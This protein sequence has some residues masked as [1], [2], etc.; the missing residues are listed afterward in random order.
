[1]YSGGTRADTTSQDIYSPI[2]PLVIL[3]NWDQSWSTT[4]LSIM[5]H[6]GEPQLSWELVYS[7]IIYHVSFKGQEPQPSVW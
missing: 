5:S 2:I 1:M 4:Q 3:L 7:L 6:S